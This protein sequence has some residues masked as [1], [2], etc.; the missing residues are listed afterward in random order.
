MSTTTTIRPVEEDAD[1]AFD[2]AARVDELRCHPT[3]MLRARVAE[4]RRE[5]Q[6]WHL[7]ELAATRV[8]DDRN[9]LDRMPDARVS[10]RT[11]KA[12]L[13]VA[14][15]LEQ[16]PALA[17]AAHE[18]VLSWD[19]LQPLCE[20]ATPDTDQ[21]WATRGQAMAP[22]QL[23]QLARRQHGITAEETRERYEARMLH[24]WT[25]KLDGM[26]CGRWKLPDVPG[27]LVEQVFEQMAERLRPAKGQAWDSLAHR[28]AD[29]LLDLVTH[30]RDVE[31]SGRKIIEVVEIHDPRLEA[32]AFVDGT[33]IS[34][35]TLSSI[36]LNAKVRRCITDVTGCH[37]TVDVRRS[38]LPRDVEQHV[39]RRDSACRV[40]G[41]EVSKNL[42]IHHTE[43]ICDYGDTRLVHKL[44]A[45]CPPHHRLMYPHGRYRLQGDAEDP[46]GL[47]LVHDQPSDD[48]P[49]D[50]HARDGPAP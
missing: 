24:T 13:E 4:A 21:E 45:I 32:G 3:G 33:P 11:E 12:N 19:Q 20:L 9:A 40:P 1:T 46:N 5:Q 18:G 6:R 22:V 30:Y 38:A 34:K 41:C 50:D 48:Q 49:S 16:R 27:R 29:A 17:A 42:Q 39:R 7:E 25:D 14:R 43:A 35:E 8:L 28:K 2:F 36:K 23:Q 26:K 10:A 15:A 31:P 47:R 44:A 37:R